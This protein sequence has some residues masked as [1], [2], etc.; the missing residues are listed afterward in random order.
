MPRTLDVVSLH[1]ACRQLKIRSDY[2]R[3]LLDGLGIEPA[4]AGQLLVLNPEQFLQVRTRVEKGR[5]ARKMGSPRI[6]HLEG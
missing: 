2:L 4:K 3:G 6:K 1:A 5:S